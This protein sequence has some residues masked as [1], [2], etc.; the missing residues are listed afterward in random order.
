MSEDNNVL[1]TAAV[2]AVTTLGGSLFAWLNGRGKARAEAQ[3]VV[4]A[5]IDS[6]VKF[7]LEEMRRENANCERRLTEALGEISGLRQ[8]VW[9]LEN[10]LRAHGIDIPKRPAPAAVVF[11]PKPEENNDG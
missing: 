8:E 10:R 7:L 4:Q 9:S 1:I 5:Q 6:T 11:T 3:G 2:G